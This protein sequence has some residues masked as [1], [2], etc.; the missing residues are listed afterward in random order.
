MERMSIKTFG[1]NLLSG[2]AIAILVG[3]IPNAIL[4]EIFK[5]LA[6]KYPMFVTL[7]HVVQSIQFTIPVLLGTAIAMK[8][9]FTPLWTVVVATASFVGSGVAQFKD[10]V[11]IL[12]GVGDLINAILTAGLSVLIILWLGKR[13]GSLGLIILPIVG[14]AGAGLI[15]LMTLPY[16]RT[17]TTEIGNMI[18][19]FTELQPILMAI[20]IS[21]AY[22]FIIISP[23]S[24]VAISLAIGING[25]AAGS[26][27]MG[28]VACEAVLVWG[29]MKVNRPGVPLTI[30]LGGVKMML[31]NMI[32]HPIILLP[33]FANAVIT[34][35][36]GALIGTGG[37][38]ES[39]G[40]GIIGLVGPINAFRFLDTSPVVSVILVTVAFFVVPFISG[41]LINFLFTKVFKVFSNDVYKFEV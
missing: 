1:N 2:V 30:F 18:N 13:V 37:T 31:P 29:T 12:M 16:V 5:A 40:F 14:G 28:V 17:I 22:S 41:W 21:L 20:L 15:G 8:F 19:Y 34:G 26:A 39:A 32:K 11:W 6:P 9:K 4:G 25:L 36:C 7:L 24:T 33:I 38:K 10:G 35:L 27:S 3:L 23:L